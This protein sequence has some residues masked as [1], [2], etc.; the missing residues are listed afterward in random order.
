MTLKG[1]PVHEIFLRNHVESPDEFRAQR[2]AVFTG[3]G[4]IPHAFENEATL[5]ETWRNRHR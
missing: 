4:A 5:I 1:G 2:K 3:Q